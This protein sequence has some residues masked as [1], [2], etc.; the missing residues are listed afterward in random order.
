MIGFI[1]FINWYDKSNKVIKI[2]LFLFVPIILAVFVVFSYM[3][4]R[5]KNTIDDSPLSDIIDNS[6]NRSNE[7]LNTAKKEAEKNTLTIKQLKKDYAEL[8]NKRKNL[9][10]ESQSNHEKIDNSN[11]FDDVASIIESQSE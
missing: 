6:D 11:N 10:E 3:K 7:D 8:K 2:I 4:N 5:F 1:K 9:K